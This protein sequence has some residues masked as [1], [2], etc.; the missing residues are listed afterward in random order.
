[1]LFVILSR[2]LL[3]IVGIVSVYGNVVC[4]VIILS[5]L[6]VVPLFRLFVF[7]VG[8]IVIGFVG[9]VL[10]FHDVVVVVGDDVV[11]VVVGFVGVAYGAVV[12]VV[13]VVGDLF[14]AVFV[15]VCVGVGIVVCSIVVVVTGVSVVV[16]VVVTRVVAMFVDDAGYVVIAGV[17]VAFV[18]VVYR[19]CRC[20]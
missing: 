9:C 19:C 8:R 5:P 18:V 7:I 12:V 20:R 10:E 16:D 17:V 6:L 4:V 15:V 14:V 11:G 1:M 13:V 3:L 2:L